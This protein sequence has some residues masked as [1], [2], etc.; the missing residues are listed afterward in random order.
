MNLLNAHC[1]LGILPG[2]RLSQGRSQ[3]QSCP[4]PPLGGALRA[5]RRAGLC[6]AGASES[7]SISNP[8][9]VAV[10]RRSPSPSRGP[11]VAPNQIQPGSTLPART[12]NPYSPPGGVAGMTHLSGSGRSLARPP[13]PTLILST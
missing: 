6:R 11:L 10:E 3:H 8:G 1:G 5:S 9:T 13:A 7:L 12:L 4:L 2:P